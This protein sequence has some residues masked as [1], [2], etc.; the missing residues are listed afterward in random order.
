[1][2]AAREDTDVAS[3]EVTIKRINECLTKSWR[4][5]QEDVLVE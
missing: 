3:I 1:M 2:R 4:H 5:E